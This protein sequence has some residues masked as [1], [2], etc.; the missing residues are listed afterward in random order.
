MNFKLFVK[1][2]VIALIFVNQFQL[3]SYSVENKNQEKEP[4]IV[5]PGNKGKAPADAIIIFDGKSLDNFESV[6]TGEPAKWKVSGKKFTV[7]PKTGNIQTKQRFSDCQLHIE[8]RI[9]KLNIR[10]GYEGQGCG[11]SGIYI[12]GKYEIQVLNSFENSTYIKGQAGAL[13]DQ[14]PP[15]VNASRKPGKWQVYDIIFK[16]PK[17]NSDG[18]EK[19][20]G[21][22][23]IF[24]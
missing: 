13:Y 20:A 2:I 8:W 21:Y 19:E 10:K 5:A 9:P 16:A 7:E 14:Y 23:T 24:S 11:N 18:T 1:S 3:V 17:Y 12:M 6:N 22:V 4:V 15:L